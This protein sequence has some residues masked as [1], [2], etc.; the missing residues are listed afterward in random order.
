VAKRRK[1]KI[2]QGAKSHATPEEP[3]KAEAKRPTYVQSSKFKVQ[4]SK[5]KVQSSK[6]KVQSSKFKVQ[7]SKFKVQSSKF[8]VHMGQDS[9]SC[10]GESSFAPT[11]LFT[12]PSLH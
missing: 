8:C 7:S 2:Q 4:S 3:L 12:A 1:K 10:G 6:F 11:I 9:E 5:F